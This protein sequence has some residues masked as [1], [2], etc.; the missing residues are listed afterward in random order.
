M[1]AGRFVVLRKAR[2]LVVAGSLLG[3]GKVRRSFAQM[4]PGNSDQVCSDLLGRRSSP[5][6]SAKF[7][8]CLKRERANDF[9]GVGVKETSRGSRL[10]LH[11][12]R[13]RPWPSR[14]LQSLGPDLKTSKQDTHYSRQPPGQDKS[15]L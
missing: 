2:R 9:P 10:G 13:H 1:E 12:P 14:D 11:S 4:K 8:A 3:G 15:H 5:R 7:F 6:L